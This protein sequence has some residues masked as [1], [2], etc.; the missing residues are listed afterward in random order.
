[1]KM[2][3]LTILIIFYILETVSLTAEMTVIHPGILR[4]KVQK[5]LCLHVSGVHWSLEAQ[6]N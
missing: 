2:N 4:V 3:I 6:I 5:G 1:M